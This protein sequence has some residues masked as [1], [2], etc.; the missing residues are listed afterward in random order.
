MTPRTILL[1]M[2]LIPVYNQRIMNIKPAVDVL[3]VNGQLLSDEEADFND[4]FVLK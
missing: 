2:T 3:V 1:S 4:V